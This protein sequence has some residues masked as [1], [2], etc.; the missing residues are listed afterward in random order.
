MG[1]VQVDHLSVV[2]ACI[3]CRLLLLIL[4]Q[5]ISHFLCLGCSVLHPILFKLSFFNVELCLLSLKLSQF[6]L[7]LSIIY[8][9]LCLCLL[10]NLEQ[11]VLLL[12]LLGI[13]KSLG[14][15][16]LILNCLLQVFLQLEQFILLPLLLLLGLLQVVLELLGFEPCFFCLGICLGLLLLK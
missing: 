5:R 9:L 7:R 6:L 8:S 11:L 2:L 3:I 4:N 16:L 14:A 10:F 15:V 13:F 1:L 12:F